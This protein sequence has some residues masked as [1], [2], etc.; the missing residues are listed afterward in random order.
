MWNKIG[1]RFFNLDLEPD[2]QISKNHCF[3]IN[4]QRNK[5]LTLSIRST[6]FIY[7]FPLLIASKHLP[8]FPEFRFSQFISAK[9]ERYFDFRRSPRL[10]WI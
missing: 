5:R 3:L 10:I 2:L 1:V 4:L 8:T 7:I 9:K 6:I